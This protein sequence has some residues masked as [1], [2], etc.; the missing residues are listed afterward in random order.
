MSAQMDYNFNL[1]IGAPGGIVDLVPHE[2]NSFANEENNGVLKPGMGVVFGTT[3]EQIKKPV[4]GKTIADFAGIVTN[5]RT[6][7]YDLDGNIRMVKGKGTGVM[8]WGRIYGRIPDE[9][10]VTV[11]EQVNLILTGDYAGCFCGATAPS[12]ASVL[13]LNGRFVG[14]VDATTLVA[15]IDLYNQIGVTSSEG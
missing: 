4:S 9:I 15:P 13:A 7:E 14:V 8:R 11:G 5:N 1:P 2:I 10:T 6:T 12:G 3:Y